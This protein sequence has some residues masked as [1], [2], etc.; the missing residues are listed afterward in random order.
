MV[1][2]SRRLGV[3]AYG[4]DLICEGPGREHWFVKHDLEEPLHIWYPDLEGRAFHYPERYHDQNVH[5]PSDH[6]P[7]RFEVVTCLEVAEHISCDRSSILVETI[8]RHV[9]PGGLLVFSAAAPGQSGEHHMNARP[10]WEWREMFYEVG[11]SYRDDY[12]KQLS[13]L[14]SWV[15]GPLMWLGANV[16]VFDS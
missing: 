12:T 2:M 3:E 1:N 15:A 14:W 8:V 16:Q 4:V 10:S 7:L 9:E 5:V 11:L 6:Y 13:H